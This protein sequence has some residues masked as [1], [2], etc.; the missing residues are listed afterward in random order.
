MGSQQHTNNTNNIMILQEK[1]EKIERIGGGETHAFTI[2]V[3]RKAFQILSDLYSDK[4]LAIMRELSCN[5]MDSHRD[6]DKADLPITIHLPNALEPYLE[7]RDYGMGIS[8]DDVIGIY[9]GYFKSTKTNSNNTVGCLGLGSKSPF[10]YTDNFTV[11]V[12]YNGVRRLYL[13]Y[14]NEEG[15]PNITLADEQDDCEGNGVAIQI[16]IK[17]DDFNLFRAACLSA[18]KWFACK[19]TVTGAA[20]DWNEIERETLVQGKGWRIM[21]KD[22][23]DYRSDS[24]SYAIMGG[25]NYPINKSKVRYE[26]QCVLC[27]TII[28]FPIGD[29]DFAPSREAL[30][31]DDRTVKM[32]N[33]W[34][35]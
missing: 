28:E 8:P 2:E 35:S 34:C 33:D 23:N 7:I 12:R 9:T 11:T 15:A 21:S 27:N 18:C 6:A 24:G 22:R 17:K 13:A 19:P 25:V 31:Y 5:A 10:C 16:P 14:F 1:N 26:L 4:P 32:L 20:V 29:L 30:S 3:S